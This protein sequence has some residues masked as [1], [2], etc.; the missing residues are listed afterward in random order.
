LQILRATEPQGIIASLDVES[1]FTNVPLETT[2]DVICQEAYNHPTMLP[3]PFDRALL[4]KLLIACTSK[5]PFTH[6]DGSMYLQKDGVSMG[7][8][9]GVTFANFYMT[10][11][12]NNIL[13]N[14]LTH[15]PAVYCRYV[16]DCYVVTSTTESLTELKEAFQLNS[17]LQFTHEIGTGHKIKNLDVHVDGSCNRTYKTSVYQKPT[18]AGIYL[19]YSSECP[20]RYKDGT[21]KALIHRTYKITS[22]WQLFHNNIEILKQSLINNGYPNKL[23]DSVLANYLSKQQNSQQP[24]PGTSHT[25]YYQNQYSQ[26][27]KVDERTIKAIVKNNTHCINQ[28]DKLKLTIYYKTN[29][30][31]SL[32]M[33]NNQSPKT[34][35]LKQTN[36]IYEYTCNNG[37]CEL[38]KCSYIGLTTTTL[39]R[40]LTMHLASGGPKMHSSNNHNITLARDMLV[41]NTKIIYRES[42]YSRL[43]I[44]EALFIQQRKPKINCQMTGTHRIL[45]LFSENHPYR[46]YGNTA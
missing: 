45:K 43:Q 4:R 24:E 5:C 26:S 38:Q 12:E 27:Y 34:P 25:V 2:V 33:R 35:P 9:L 10:H 28:T 30:I 16:D 21:I 44:I 8:P 7:S 36:I 31:N 40:R 37:E 42:N 15:K 20:Q 46:A 13:D 32:V 18:N 11:I 29:A 19:N 23:F 41:N 22:D 1:L 17:V 14:I 39:S 6:M 3:P